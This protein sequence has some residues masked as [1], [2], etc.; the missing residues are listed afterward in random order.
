[1]KQMKQGQHPDMDQLLRN[2]PQ[3]ADTALG[4]LYATPFL[5]AKIDR[6]A[7]EKKQG[8]ARF[9]MPRW[10]PAITCAALVLVLALTFLPMESQPTP[11]IQTNALGPDSEPTGK[12]TSDLSKGS[13]FI[14]NSASAPGYRSIWSDVSDG[15]FPLIGLNGKYY[16]MLTSPNGVDASILGAQV[17]SIAEFTTEPSLSGTDVTLSNAAASGTAVYGISGISAD[18]LVAA[19]VN[20]RMRLFQ[21]VSF[22]GNALRGKE[23]LIDTLDISGRVI[24]M[25]LSGVGTVTDPAA[26]ATLF[27]T[28][29]D[30]ASFESRG[31]ISSRQ[32]L[33]IEMDNGLVV[34]MA[35][36]GDTMAACG[37]W[38]CPEF[39]EQFEAYCN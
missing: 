13:L 30:N 21:R 6:A 31:S 24:A 4:G 17:A 15:A 34:Q 9:T 3:Q 20:G 27:A 11:L 12:L 1:M 22:N 2:L 25:E 16:R 26:C 7:A 29:T 37:V 5:K 33:L 39:F 14:T 28:L 35:V 32:A 8:R 18:T 23:T 38:S 36:K 19:E 10:L